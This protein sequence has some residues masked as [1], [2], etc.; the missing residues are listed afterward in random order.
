MMPRVSIQIESE[1]CDSSEVPDNKNFGHWAAATIETSAE[2]GVRI[3]GSAEG[4]RY[5]R[6]YRHKDYATNVLSF[7]FETHVFEEQNY[8][9]DV[10]MTASVIV[11][12]ARAQNKPLLSHWAHLFIHALLH[13]QGY[14]HD[15]DTEARA[16]E[17]QESK[18]MATLGFPDP[19]SCDSNEPK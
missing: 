14:R 1:S 18:I 3:V 10:L 12:E 8:L 15:S 7:P 13:L 19:W 11:Q 5:N 16:M 6:R 2:V 17:A 4:R 9:G